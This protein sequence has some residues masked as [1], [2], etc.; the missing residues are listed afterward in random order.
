[1]A[2]AIAFLVVVGD[3]P[4]NL[5][6]NQAVIIATLIEKNCP[7]EPFDEKTPSLT[8]YGWAMAAQKLCAIQ[9]ESRSETWPVCLQQRTSTK[10]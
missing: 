10:T 1:M 6:M 9:L 5:P 4:E 7:T 8:E 2:C 3:T